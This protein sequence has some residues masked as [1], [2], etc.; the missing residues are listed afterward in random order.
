MDVTI[1]AKEKPDVGAPC[2]QNGQQSSG[3]N[4]LK[5]LLG[6]KFAGSQG[7]G[8]HH[9]GSCSKPLEE[10]SVWNAKLA[11]ELPVPRGDILGPIS[12]T[13]FTSHVIFIFI[14]M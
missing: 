4:R 14:L 12:L 3:I 11:L 9:N 13:E 5:L 6:Q 2:L 1:A 8:E 10:E 7:K